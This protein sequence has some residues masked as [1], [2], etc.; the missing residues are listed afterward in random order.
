VKRKTLNLVVS[1]EI[2]KMGK[3]QAVPMAASN[4]D[5][6]ERTRACFRPGV[7]DSTEQHMEPKD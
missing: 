2:E 7:A 5:R 3:A 4:R 6:I 1:P